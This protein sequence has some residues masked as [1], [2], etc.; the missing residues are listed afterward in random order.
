MIKINIKNL[1]TIDK[2]GCITRHNGYE[3]CYILHFSTG[4]NEGVMFQVWKGYSASMVFHDCEF[5]DD[6]TKLSLES[7]VKGLELAL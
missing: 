4:D 2:S 7:I 3:E 1:E 5:V 6:I